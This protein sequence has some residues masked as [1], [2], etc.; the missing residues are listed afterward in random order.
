MKKLLVAVLLMFPM[1]QASADSL[2]DKCMDGAV[3]NPDFAKCGGEWM[4]RADVQLN[5]AWKELNVGMGE[6]E[7]SKK[8]LLVEQRLW[9]AYKEESCS[10][11]DHTDFGRMGDVIEFPSCRARVIEQRVKELKSYRPEEY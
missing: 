10:F 1:S 11:Y 7:L 2:Y 4:A 8:A 5:Q 9:N 6:R 3:T